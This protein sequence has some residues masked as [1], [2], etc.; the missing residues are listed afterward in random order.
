MHSSEIFIPA[1]IAFILLA[2][3]IKGVDTAQEFM[4]GARESLLI[5]FEILPSL[6]LTMTAV[7]MFS[8]SGA[9]DIIAGAVSPVTQF[10]GF[11]KECIS[12]AVIR[13]FSGSGALCVLE[14]TLSKVP[15]DSYAG[16][17]ASVVMGS[18]ET[19]FY[20]I[21]V[22]FAAIKQKAYPAVFAGAC[23]ADLC[24]FVLSALAVR[25]FF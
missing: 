2:G 25:V 10:L 19:T 24:G 5:A 4:L 3:V 18:T 14:D 1:V 15:P 11:P 21:S 23:F 17:V 6:I 12:L 20:T 7:G 9:V 16:R 22:Y 8:A 13:P